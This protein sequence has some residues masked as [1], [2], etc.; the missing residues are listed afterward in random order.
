MKLQNTFFIDKSTLVKLVVE[1]EL[2]YQGLNIPWR[3]LYVTINLIYH[4]Y[5]IN[6]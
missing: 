4:D 6:I 5:Q 1:W 2:E 3:H